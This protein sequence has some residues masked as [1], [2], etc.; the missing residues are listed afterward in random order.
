MSKNIL[1]I[2]S[3]L[4]AGSNSELIS[5]EVAH[6][7]QSSGNRVE[8]VSLK[9]KKIEFCIGCLKCQ[10]QGKCILKDDMSELI[11]KVNIA[12]T[13][14]F[15]TPIYYYEMSGLLKTFLD[16]CNPLYIRDYHFRE[17]YLITA[18]A[19]NSQT[20][21][22]RAKSGIEGFVECFP[23][24]EFKGVFSGGGLTNPKEIKTHD[25]IL[26]RAFAFGTKI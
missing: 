13:L 4:R 19:E 24:A 11:E 25:E 18:S 9:N 3:S 2:S 21:Y 10:K 22:Q 15:S 6:G 23:N 5:K 1:I 7:A 26:E 12:D 20:V 16:R 17:V 14:V 8:F